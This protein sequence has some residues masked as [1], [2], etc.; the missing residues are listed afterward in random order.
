[1]LD[2]KHRTRYEVEVMCR[3]M[4]LK[5]RCQKCQLRWFT[6]PNEANIFTPCI[7]LGDGLHFRFKIFRFLCCFEIKLADVFVEKF[8]F[9]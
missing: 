4:L 9:T 5:C 2:N 8:I 1:M 6:R 7:P 3:Q